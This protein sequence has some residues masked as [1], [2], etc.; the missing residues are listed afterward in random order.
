MTEL[1]KIIMKRD[2]ISSDEFTD[3][4]IDARG[5]FIDGWEPESILSDTF[6]IEPDYLFDLMAEI[7]LLDDQA[8]WVWM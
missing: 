1:R 8:P 3:L 2:G 4:V 6:G 7:E 5:D